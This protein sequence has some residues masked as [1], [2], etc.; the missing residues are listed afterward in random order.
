MNRFLLIG[1][2]TAGTVIIAGVWGPLAPLL[3]GVFGLVGFAMH[4][5]AHYLVAVLRGYGNI[6]WGWDAI[7]PYIEYGQEGEVD[8]AVHLA[9]AWI[10]LCFAAALL[11]TG[12]LPSVRSI[13]T[14]ALVAFFV[15]LMVSPADWRDVLSRS[16][17]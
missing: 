13:Q 11:V 14:P 10:G 4:E 15:V 3:T 16:T 7:G 9:P 17:S 1:G 5:T 2:A 6:N 8:P 12:P